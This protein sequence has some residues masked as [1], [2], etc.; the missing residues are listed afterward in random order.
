MT[1]KRKQEK[2]AGRQGEEREGKREKT[3]SRVVSFGFHQK[4]QES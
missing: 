3:D 4:G 2:E 1:E